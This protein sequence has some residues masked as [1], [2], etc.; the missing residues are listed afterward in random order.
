M[1]GA[2]CRHCSEAHPFLDG[3][4]YYAFADS[5]AN[6]RNTDLAQFTVHTGSEVVTRPTEKG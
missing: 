6:R 1:L 2:V 5:D 3:G 4:F